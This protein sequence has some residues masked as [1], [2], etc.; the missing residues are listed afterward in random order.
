MNVNLKTLKA[1]FQPTIL[2]SL[3][4]FLCVLILPC[5][6][7]LAEVYGPFMGW[8]A[9]KECHTE[10]SDGWVKTR[11]ARA[12]ESLVRSGQQDL[13]ECLKCHVV[14]YNQAGGFLD[15]ELTMEL[16]GVQ[17]ESCH[18]P[19]ERHL[20]MPEESGSIV[21]TPAKDLCRTCHTIGQDPNFDYQKKMAFSHEEE[22]SHSNSQSV[23][24]PKASSISK[25]YVDK[26]LI[27]IP[28]VDEGV[29]VIANVFLKNVGDY[30]IHITDLVSS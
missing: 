27:E 5:H 12:F 22:S 3:L 8:K 7:A 29:P 17:C 30:D 25:L 14:G 20:N 1:I 26:T 11:H 6:S 2:H 19:G 24:P 9:C 21:R 4:A 15:S 18:G 23:P 28:S 10:I 13:P 16:S